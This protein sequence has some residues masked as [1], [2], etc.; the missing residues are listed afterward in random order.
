MKGWGGVTSHRL[1]NKICELGVCLYFSYVLAQK[2]GG[3]TSHLFHPPGS[4]LALK[5]LYQTKLLL[6]Q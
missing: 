3:V 1:I 4:A 5:Y 2:G 6:R